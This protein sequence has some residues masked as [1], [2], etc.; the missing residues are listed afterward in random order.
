MVFFEI[1]EEHK[2]LLLVE[3]EQVG[4]AANNFHVLIMRHLKVQVE[5]E[6]LIFELGRVVLTDEPRAVLEEL[7]GHRILDTLLSHV[8]IVL[9]QLLD[10]LG[11]VDRVAKHQVDD[12]IHVDT[13]LLVEHADQRLQTKLL[14][15]K[16]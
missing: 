1:A 5:Q 3:A 15:L 11:Q 9:V 8:S 13:L 4:E 10:A 7:K 14:R 2:H 12:A 16:V 6:Q